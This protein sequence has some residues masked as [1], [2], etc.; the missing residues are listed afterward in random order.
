MS[1]IKREH[2]VPEFY[3]RNFVSSDN[4][5]WVFDKLTKTH[6]ETNIS[7]VANERGFYDF[8][9]KQVANNEE[10]QIVESSLSRLENDFK[11]VLDT[12]LQMITT[13]QRITRNQKRDM[14]SFMTVQYMRTLEFRNYLIESFDKFAKVTFAE[15]YNL[16]ESDRST[17]EELEFNPDLASIHHA[18]TMLDS[19][20]INYVTTILQKH[21]WIIGINNSSKPF[22][23]SDNPVVKK[24]HKKD[25][26]HSTSGF[27]SEG[28]EAAFPLTPQ[29]TLMLKGR[30]FFKE[31][32]NLDCKSKLL[33]KKEVMY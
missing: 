19:D 26:I 27:E 10:R 5:I 7:N 12:T 2:F 9:E 24:A 30:K 14:A 29:Y 15:T 32:K 4:Q 3:L 18:D 1:K 31:L 8:S 17:L 13:K 21:I 6:F 25:P 23:T 16:S 28:I 22:Y 11:R 20:I 33:N